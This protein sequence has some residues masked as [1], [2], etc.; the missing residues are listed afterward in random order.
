MNTHEIRGLLAELDLDTA[1]DDSRLAYFQQALEQLGSFDPVALQLPPAEETS[2]GELATALERLAIEAD[3]PAD[4][5]QRLFDEA[6]LCRRSTGIERLPQRDRILHYFYLCADAVMAERTAELRMLLRVFEPATELALPPDTSWLDEV[7]LRTA[8][9]FILLCRK[10][11]GWSDVRAAGEEVRAL[12]AMQRLREP[13]FLSEAVD[14]LAAAAPLIARYNLGKVIDLTASYIVSGTPGDALVQVDRHTSNVTAIL[15]LQADSELTHVS[16]LLQLGAGAL[17]RSSI[18][19]ETRRLGAKTRAFI[20]LLTDEAS[21]Q[22]VLELWPSQRAALGGS[23]LD[24]AKRAIVVQMP[25]SAGKTLIAEFAAVQALALNP[26]SRVAYVVPTRA[27]VN[28]ITLRLRSHFRPLGYQVEAAVPVFELDPTEDHLLRQQI[29]C[30]VVTPEKLD[31]LVRTGHPSVEDL[32]L[33]I[34]DEAHNLGGDERGARLE[35]L[36]GTIKRER[37]DARFLLLTPFVPNADELATWLGDDSEGTIEVRWKPN[38]RIAAAARWVKPRGRPHHLQLLTLPSAQNVDISQEVTVDLGETGLDR[39]Q[40]KKAV[41]ISASVRLAR[42]GGVLVL[43]QGRKTAEDRAQEV[44]EL[45]TSTE[46]SQFG[47]AVIQYARS[48]LGH[49]HL[50]PSLLER[51]VAYHHAGLSHDLRYL[52]ELLVDSEQVK[53]V[54]GTTTLAQGVNF[55]IATVVVETLRKPLGDRRGWVELSYSEFWN[56]AGRAGRALRDRLGLVVF[57]T[58]SKNDLDHAREYLQKEAVELASAL[59]GALET[60]TEAAE[61]FDL[62]FVRQ[63]K[64]LAV[65]M[66]YLT[67]A[68]RVAGYEAASSDIEDL[69]RSSLVFHQA[70]RKGRD[71]AEDLIRTARRYLESVGNRNPGY[72]ALA[73]GTGFSLPSVDLLYAIPRSEHPE[74]R[75]QDFWQPDQL[76]GSDLSGLESVVEIL[77]DVPEL[78]LGRFSEGPFDPHA[79]A[80]IISDW[81]NGATVS[82]IAD[83]WFTKYENVNERRRRASHYLYSSLVG[84]IPWGMGAL[85]KLTMDNPDLLAPVA[86]VP[87]AVF[88][89]VRSKEAITLRMAGVPRV[90]AEGLASYWRNAHREPESFDRIRQWLSD[91]GPGDWNGAL[92]P[93]S[94]LTGQECRQVWEALAGVQ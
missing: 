15:E 78:T 10:G 68:L 87:S 69:L 76:F 3:G 32:S 55:P 31:L 37:A 53:I 1:I 54:C 45:L 86:H 64:S 21:E 80:G 49:D 42:R 70:R 25:T 41:S 94:E 81:V 75:S 48:E 72:L 93:G 63:N 79:V 6:F 47:H 44:A 35:L 52:I 67:H 38:E 19:F 22:P 33:V 74:L 18:W 50:L 29:D 85:L 26:G 34:A 40:S 58:G 4:E 60:T 77:A 92:P 23:L 9:A 27:L 66:Q 16:D 83:R 5:R 43:T 65:F 30:L 2:A 17:I 7:L 24:P 61:N 91:L 11:D 28:Q 84:Q 8:R 73:D 12:R 88:Y 56:I 90:A 59:I 46:Q 82:S 71:L 20:R 14:K 39:R 89:G 62:R 36:L 13:P 57:P 51:G